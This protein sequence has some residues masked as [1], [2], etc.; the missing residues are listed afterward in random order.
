[1]NAVF[2]PTASTSATTTS[3]SRARTARQRATSIL[4]NYSMLW[5]LGVVLLVAL[6]VYPSFFDVRNLQIL[7]TQAA[8]LGIVAVAMTLVVIAGGFDLSPGAV[9]ALGAVTFALLANSLPVVLAAVITL[10]LSLGLGS[11]NA[12]TVTR[13]GVNPFIATLGTASIFGGIAYLVSQSSPIVVSDPAFGWLGSGAILGVPVSIWLLAGAF[14]VGGVV[15]HRTVYGRW[16]YI[17]GGSAE[18]ARLVGLRVRSLTGSTYV[19]L[20]GCAGLAGMIMSSRLMVA[21]GNMGTTLA[22]DAI[23]VVI[24]GGASLFGGEGAMW[25]TAVGLLIV[26]SLNNLFD[27]LAIDTNWQSIAKGA[28]IIAAVALDYFRRKRGLG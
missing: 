21:Q 22:L 12:L 11:V 13:L 15:L 1:M 27:S 26:V 17:I 5:L 18:A 3:P 28:I 9:F 7:L 10:L 23:T 14:I 19:L 20:A 2:S 24:I 8:P 25:R 4:M 6:W 16:L